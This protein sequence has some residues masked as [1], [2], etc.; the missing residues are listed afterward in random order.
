MSYVLRNGDSYFKEWSKIGPVFTHDPSEAYY[1][2]T[3]EQALY[4]SGQHFAFTLYELAERLPAP[5]P[6]GG[7]RKMS[8]QIAE[9]IDRLENLNGALQL[10]LRAEMHVEQLKKALPEVI[11]KLKAAYI[12]EFDDNPWE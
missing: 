2:S 7:G 4:E 12:F 6:K 11:A 3:K 5:R 9:M 1:F 8:E 10:P